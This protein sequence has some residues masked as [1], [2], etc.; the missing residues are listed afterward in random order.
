LRLQELAKES[1]EASEV[2]R[3]LEQQLKLAQA[4][5]KKL[6]RDSDQIQKEVQQAERRLQEAQAALRKAREEIEQRERESDQTKRL[7]ALEKHQN[8]LAASQEQEK[9]L[10]HEISTNLQRYQELEPQADDAKQR[11]SNLE[12]QMYSV[13]KKIKDL[14][15]SAGNQVNLYGGPNAAKLATMVSQTVIS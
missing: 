14:Q 4:P 1:E 7:Q 12:R 9:I 5:L 6:Q 15:S 2:K 3:Q 8:D 13:D 11:A 10:R